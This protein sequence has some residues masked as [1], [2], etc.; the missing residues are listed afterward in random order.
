MILTKAIAL[1]SVQDSNNLT[2]CKGRSVSGFGGITARNVCVMCLHTY[3]ACA[4]KEVGTFKNAFQ[5][6]V[7]LLCVPVNDPL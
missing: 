7:L 5:S 1:Q 3:Y 4:M 6:V 2:S